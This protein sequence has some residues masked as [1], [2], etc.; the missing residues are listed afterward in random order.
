MTHS[1]SDQIALNSREAAAFM[2]LSV[3]TFKRG[4]KS[5]HIPNGFETAPRGHRR[6]HRATLEALLLKSAA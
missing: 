3:C 4:I 1:T 5:G 6:W 2:R